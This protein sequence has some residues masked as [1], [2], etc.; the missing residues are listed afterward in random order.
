MIKRLLTSIALVA[1]CFMLVARDL[2]QK[3]VERRE[4][5]ERDFR[6][7]FHKIHNADLSEEKEC[8]EV[9]RSV[10]RLNRLAF[11]RINALNM[12]YCVP[13]ANIADDWGLLAD[14]HMELR[15]EEE[16]RG[17]CIGLN[18]CPYLTKYSEMLASLIVHCQY[19]EVQVEA[20]RDLLETATGQKLPPVDPIAKELQAGVD[21]DRRLLEEFARQDQEVDPVNLP[22]DELVAEARKI[23]VKGIAEYCDDVD[24][25]RQLRDIHS[26]LAQIAFERD[27]CWGPLFGKVKSEPN[28]EM[29]AKWYEVLYSESQRIHVPIDVIADGLYL[30]KKA[31]ENWITK[32][33]CEKRYDKAEVDRIRSLLEPFMVHRLRIDVGF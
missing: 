1:H 3:E 18:G 30:K 28:W 22:F 20:V 6:E 9:F 5:E 33:V 26:R 24:R 21:H 2:P 14:Y 16:R 8:D 27:S 32:A 31:I 17:R 10:L 29:I 13:S 12:H 23:E 25:A 4:R 7:S 19:S 11:R 15:R